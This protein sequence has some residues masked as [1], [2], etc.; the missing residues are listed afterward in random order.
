MSGM[1]RIVVT[2]TI[3]NAVD[4]ARSIRCE[5]L[6]DKGATYL[7]LPSAWRDRL[8]DL[9]LLRTIRVQAANQR[10]ITGELRGPVRVEIEGFG[11]VFAEVLFIEMEPRGNGDFLPLIGYLVLEAIPV[12]VDMARHRLV[13]TMADLR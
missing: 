3:T 1:S 12:E 11:A 2:V 6:V 13:P 9:E 8:G 10:R 5:A 7:T 4:R